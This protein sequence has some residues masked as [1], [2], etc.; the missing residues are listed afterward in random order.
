[1]GKVS[2]DR[3]QRFRTEFGYTQ[4]DLAELCGVDASCISRWETGKWSPST[5]NSAR[6]AKALKVSV[7]DLYDDGE[8]SKQAVAEFQELKPQER[9]LVLTLIRELK[10]L[11]EKD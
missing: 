1:M 7:E 3:I 6:L 11:R 8:A 2:P 9:G 10:K 4:E 5:A